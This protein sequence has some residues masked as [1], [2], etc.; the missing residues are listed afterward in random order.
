MSETIR[1]RLAEFLLGFA[2]FLQEDDYQR[3]NSTQFWD[4]S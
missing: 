2:L 4:E 1:T 3:A